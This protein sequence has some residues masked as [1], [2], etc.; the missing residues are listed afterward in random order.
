MLRFVSQLKGVIAYDRNIIIL[1]G[2]YLILYEQSVNF[3]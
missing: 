1:G 2:A 3:L